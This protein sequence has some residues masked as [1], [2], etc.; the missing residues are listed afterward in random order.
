MLLDLSAAFDTVEHSVLLSRLSTSF[1]I[2][3][4]A[5]EWFASYLS[6]RSQRVSLSGKCS[7]SLQLNQGVPQGSC[8]G[9]L[10]F[11]LHFGELIL[12]LAIISC[13]RI[14]RLLLS[15]L[16]Q[17]DICNVHMMM[18]SP[19]G[20]LCSRQKFF[21]TSAKLSFFCVSNNLQ[22]FVLAFS[23]FNSPTNRIGPKQ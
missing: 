7:E 14:V 20:F 19:I 15:H 13:T 17:A 2:R 12:V 5:L 10:L 22:E 23:R 8:L 3:G 11:C 1:E 16:M 4:T 21:S 18:R 6:G 9:P